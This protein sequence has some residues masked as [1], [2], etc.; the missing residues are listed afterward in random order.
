M[1]RF[2]R[3]NLSNHSAEL[4]LGEHLSQPRPFGFNLDRQPA[5][6]DDL[7]LYSGGGHLCTVAPTRAGKGTGAIVPNLL[8]YRGPVIVFDPKGENYSVTARARQQMGHTIVKLDPFGIAGEATDAINPLD[9]LLLPNADAETDSQTL[10]ETFSRGMKGTKEPFW[11]NSAVSLLAALIMAAATRTAPHRS[12][13]WAFD[14]LSSDDVV[15]GIAKFL[16]ESG[17]QIP[18]SAYR[19]IASFLQITDVTRSG[20]LSTTQAYVKM[21]GSARVRRSFE[22]ST[23]SLQDIVAGKPLSIYMILPSERI[24]SHSSLL[25]LWLATFFKAIL[26]RR[27]QPPQKTLV[28]LDEAGQLGGFPFLETMATLCAGYGLWLWLIYQDLAQLQAAF[29]QSWRTILNNCGVLQVFGMNNRQMASAWAECL[30]S[31]ANELRKLPADEQM[32]LIQGHGEI[33]SRRINYLTDRRFRGSFDANTLFG[34]AGNDAAA[35]QLP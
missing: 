8:H 29:P 9:A 28:L 23:F 4:L 11:D 26:A 7:I 25:K 16:D 15:Y 34:A 6:R 13:S 12:L 19:E 18:A 14:M 24:E 27:V 3:T 21:L 33:R 20:I 17:K 35:S 22:Q 10:A 5:R 30:D 2:K 1:D 32:L 31:S